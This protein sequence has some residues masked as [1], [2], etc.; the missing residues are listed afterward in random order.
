MNINPEVM[1]DSD[2]KEFNRFYQLYQAMMIPDLPR[3]FEHW[4]YA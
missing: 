3:R 2:Q 4:K 1:L